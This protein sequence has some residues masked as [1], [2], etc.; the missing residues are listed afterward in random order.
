VAGLSPR[1]SRPVNVNAADAN[2]EVEAAILKVHRDL[3]ALGG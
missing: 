2:S 3:E 1:E